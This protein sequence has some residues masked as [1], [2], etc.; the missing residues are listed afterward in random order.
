V[1]QER[2]LPIEVKNLFGTLRAAFP[3][4]PGNDRSRR[5][6]RPRRSDREAVFGRNQWVQQDS[7]P[8]DALWIIALGRKYIMQFPQRKLHRLKS[9]DY[10][11]NGYYHITICTHKKRKILASISQTGL[12]C[13]VIPTDIGSMV[14]SCWER[15]E[16][17]Y[18]YI[19]LDCYCLMPNHL[20]GIIIIDA[21]EGVEHPGLSEL[22][23]GF[24]SITTREYNKRVSQSDKNTLWQSSFYDEIIRDEE[25]LYNTRNYIA[26]NPSKWM[27]DAMYME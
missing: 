14:I 11:E 7:V 17:V 8:Y 21:P 22:M 23:H 4:A 25:M 15:M 26:G 3:T 24:K 16:R 20:H 19:K 13:A 9:W 1:Q 10:S 5:E 18:P 27:E 12:D 6:R 2:F